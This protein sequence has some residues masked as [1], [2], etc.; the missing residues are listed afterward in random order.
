MEKEF[1][2]KVIKIESGATYQNHVYDQYVTLELENKQKIKFF[3][4][5]CR[6][7]KN[8][9]EKKVK[10]QAVMSSLRPKEN[11]EKKQE[12]I[13]T[14]LANAKVSGKISTIGKIKSQFSDTQ[15]N[16]YLIDTQYAKFF[17]HSK[18]PLKLKKGNYATFEEYGNELSIGE[19]QVK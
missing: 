1:E 15:Y 12:I 19:V 4:Q 18:D 2:A 7:K 14:I 6:I 17:I 11:P 10:V 3:D 9:L 13:Q 5:A 16:E 8:M